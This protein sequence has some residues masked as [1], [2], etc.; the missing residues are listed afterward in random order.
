M[1]DKKGRPYI[2]IWGTHIS[3]T[4]VKTIYSYSERR[5]FEFSFK[6]ITKPKQS[7]LTIQPK[8]L[9]TKDHSVMQLI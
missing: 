9:N 1:K 3:A 2:K 6:G 5:K 4:N 8:T 7:A